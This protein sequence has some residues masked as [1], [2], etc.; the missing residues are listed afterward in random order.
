MN[1]TP[2]PLCTGVLALLAATVFTLT[3]AAQTPQAAPPAGEPPHSFPAPTNLKVLPKDFTGQQVH[4]TM[5]K[6]AGSLGVHCGTCHASDPNNLG[7][8]GK[9][10]LKFADDSKPEKATA[11]LMYTMLQQINKDY[12]SKID[13]ENGPVTCGTCHRGKLAPEPYVIPEENHGPP[14]PAK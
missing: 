11:R 6:W 3:A 9:P 8:N 12:I 7:P 5:E 4:D 1:K 14:P 13:V 2:S 10:R